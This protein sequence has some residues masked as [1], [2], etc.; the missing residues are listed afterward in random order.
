[1]FI[2]SSR[3]LVVC[4]LKDSITLVYHL[5]YA[6]LSLHSG[7]LRSITCS[8]TRDHFYTKDLNIEISDFLSSRTV[9]TSL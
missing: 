5:L 3:K 9:E 4:G 2:I 7:L 1:M 6:I 8:S